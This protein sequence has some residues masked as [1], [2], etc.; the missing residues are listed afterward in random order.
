MGKRGA[1][2]VWN[3]TVVARRPGTADDEKRFGPRRGDG[4][5]GDVGFAGLRVESAPEPSPDPTPGPLPAPEPDPA[6]DPDPVPPAA[7]SP[8]QF[9]DPT[10]EDIDRLWD[11][12]RADPAPAPALQAMK[13][14]RELREAVGRFAIAEA[15]GTGLLRSIQWR[16]THVG[17]G[18]LAPIVG[19]VGMAH[20]YLDPRHRGA[21]GVRIL[22]EAVSQA[23]IL[24]PDLQLVV[25]VRT[26]RVQSLAARLGLTQRMYV[27]MTEAED[28]G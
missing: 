2:R 22:R 6:P 10:E 3:P 25:M 24:R 17:F 9:T 11:W 23:R 26:R 1:A 12:I 21:A 20:G 7:T 4:G 5:E 16:G 13:T 8:L 14:S 18:Y 19:G 28:N 27:A 15:E